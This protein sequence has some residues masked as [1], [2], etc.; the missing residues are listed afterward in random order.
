MYSI[1]TYIYVYMYVFM[2]IHIWRC[3]SEYYVLLSYKTM[4]N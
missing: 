1:C 4:T 3:T 2:C